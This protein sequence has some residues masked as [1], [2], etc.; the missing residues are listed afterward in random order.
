M[1]AAS[2]YLFGST[3]HNCAKPQSDIDVF[4]D[5]VTTRPFTL[6]ELVRIRD[7]LSKKLD[8]SVDLTTRNSLHPKLRGS[9][10]ASAVKVF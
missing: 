2:L 10:Q 9:I 4:I 1:G 5:P 6:V 3:A 7:Y 8:A